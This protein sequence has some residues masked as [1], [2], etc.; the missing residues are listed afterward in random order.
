M[1]TSKKSSP[2]SMFHPPFIDDV[3]V[4]VSCCVSFWAE[5]DD[6]GEDVTTDDDSDDVGGGDFIGALDV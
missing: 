2:L 1:T 4:F 6:D 5:F 3:F